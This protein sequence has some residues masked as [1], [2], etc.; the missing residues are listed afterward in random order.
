MKAAKMEAARWR[1]RVMK[2]A[3]MEAAKM[4]A[5]SARQ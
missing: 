4:E 2:A 1:Q 3:K 5:A